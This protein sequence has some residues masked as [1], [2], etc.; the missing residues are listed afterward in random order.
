[1][2]ESEKRAYAD[3]DSYPPEAKPAIACAHAKAVSAFRWSIRYF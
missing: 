2:E 1:M 3:S